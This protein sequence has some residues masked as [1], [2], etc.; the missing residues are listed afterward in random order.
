MCGILGGINI[1]KNLLKNTLNYLRHRGPDDSGTFFINNIALLHTRLSIQDLTKG[2]QPFTRSQYVIVY[3]GE[4]YNHKKLR[5]KYSLE[6][7][8]NSDTET[9][10]A[11]YEALG[12]DFLNELD[13]MFAFAIYDKKKSTLLLA[14]DRA[15]KKPL[16]YF[17]H[18]K[19]FGFCSELNAISKLENFSLDYK[20][21]HQFLRYGFIGNTTPYKEIFELEPGSYMEVNINTLEIRT[22]KWWSIISFYQKKA[23]LDIMSAS[24]HLEELLDESV[25]TRLLSSDLEVGTFLS[26]GI[27]SGLI[28]AFARKHV[29]KLKTFTIALEGDYDESHLAKSVSEKYETDHK[30]INIS[31]GNLKNDL[32]KILAGYGEPFGDSSAIPSYYISKEAKKYITVVLNGDGADELFGGYRRYV[33]FRYYDYFK[34]SN[35]V[36]NISKTIIHV[37]PFPG[38]K[39][40]LYNYFYRLIFLSKYPPLQAYLASTLDSFEG[41]ENE[42]ITDES[43]DLFYELRKAIEILNASNLSGLQK[44]MILDFDFMLPIDLLVKMD[45]ATMLNSLEGRSPFLGR[46]IMEFAPGLSDNF[47][48]KG[49]QTKYLLRFM[50]RKYLPKLITVQPKRGFEVP[51]RRWVEYDLRDLID[52]YLSDCK[53]S[54]TLIKKSF[55]KKLIYNKVPVPSEKRVK[56]IWYILALEIWYR[57]C[58]LTY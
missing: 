57:K 47:K 28:T 37:L 21:L 16:Y 40:S 3:N 41:F 19:K 43:F 38:K 2:K 23:E 55:I 18:N 34:S 53:I 39:Q 46:D 9:L 51:L 11:L 13:G 12:I 8:T 10:L 36:K 54:T 31:Y 6:C 30:I 42:L 15:G 44:I 45:I 7:F 29:D 20:N 4:I 58:F 48:I 17:C 50:A 22:R 52:D 14:R 1:D 49:N 33:P 26:G 24:E 25:K 56:M 32:E 5:E 27:D 35:L